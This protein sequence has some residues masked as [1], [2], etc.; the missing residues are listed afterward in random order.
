MGIADTKSPPIGY[1]HGGADPCVR[2]WLKVRTQ[3]RPYDDVP[4][5]LRFFWLDGY[6]TALPGDSYG[7]GGHILQWSQSERS[8]QNI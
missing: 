6:A 7:R 4:L 8:R 2:P 1:F 3:V 5:W